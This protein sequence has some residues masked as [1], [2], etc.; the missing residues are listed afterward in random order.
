M[1]VFTESQQCVLNTV[2]AQRSLV[3]SWAQKNNLEI[4][5]KNLTEEEAWGSGR[6]CLYH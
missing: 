1:L 5:V 3:S 4:K 2:P 6:I